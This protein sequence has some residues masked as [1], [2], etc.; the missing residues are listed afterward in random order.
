MQHLMKPVLGVA[1]AALLMT[2]ACKK[3]D[4]VKEEGG[5]EKDVF[6]SLTVDEVETRLK[7]TRDGKDKLF[8]YDNNGRER[9]AQSHVPS[10]RWVDFKSV[11]VED[12]P[13]DKDAA[14]VFYCANEH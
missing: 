5:Q 4:A 1:M 6:G 7:A 12:L 8:V 9:Y 14:L 3:E 10:A 11:K 13:A 2:G